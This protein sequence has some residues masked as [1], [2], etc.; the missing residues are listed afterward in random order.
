[1]LICPSGE[2]SDSTQRSS[3]SDACSDVLASQLRVTDR[4]DPLPP[5]P[6]EEHPAASALEASRT[7]EKVP[8]KPY[9]SIQQ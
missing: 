4:G 9:G 8:E 7:S 5:C 1:M 6:L 3:P 2:K